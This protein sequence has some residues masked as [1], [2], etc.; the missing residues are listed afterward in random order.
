MA[1]PEETLQKRYVLRKRLGQNRA[2]TWLAWDRQTQTEVVI[3]ELA[4]PHLQAWKDWELFEREVQT[5]QNLSIPNVPR[6]L[7]HFEQ[8]HTRYLVMQYLTGQSL[9]EWLNSGQRC[10]PDLLK[11]WAIQIL[12]ILSALHS[13]NPPLVHRDL[14]PG[15]LIWDGQRLSLVD[16]GGVMAT[17]QPRGG[18]TVTG[19]Y[20]YMAPE[21]FAGRASPA[22]DLYSLGATLIHLATGKPPSELLNQQLQLDFEAHLQLSPAW[23]SWLKKLISTQPQERFQSAKE[24]KLALA[25]LDTEKA[26]GPTHWQALLAL[27]PTPSHIRV[28]QTEDNLKVS[29]PHV[30][31]SE[32]AL[33]GFVI[34]FGLMVLLIFWSLSNPLIW[35]VVAFFS[36]PLI[37]MPFA[38]MHSVNRLELSPESIAAYKSWGF[39]KRLRLSGRPEELTK[40]RWD[41]VYID[42]VNP[43]GQLMLSFGFNYVSLGRYVSLDE[44]IWLHSL[45]LAWLEAHLSESDYAKLAA[46]SPGL[47]QDPRYEQWKT[48]YSKRV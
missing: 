40:L 29:L 38:G 46:E 8:A 36:L 21:Q 31:E 4:L 30:L 7:G 32:Q 19:T 18:S 2:T 37:W 10:D 16:F 22:S 34:W 26:T 24:A 47:R 33:I 27:T 25:E 15:N 45:I 1:A 5:L 39:Y 35:L 48:Q 20:G 23:I 17:L 41:E 6:Y 12:E 44:L 3:K 9:A 28:V 14:K 43:C 13:L 42:A 11:N